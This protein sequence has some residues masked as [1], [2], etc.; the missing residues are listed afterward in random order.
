MFK[1]IITSTVIIA[2]CASCSEKK[3]KQEHVHG[4]GCNHSHAGSA[5]TQKYNQKKETNAHNHDHSIEAAKALG[6]VKVQGIDCKVS[7]S[8]TASFYLVPTKPLAKNTVIR[9][10]IINGNGAESLKS[11]ATFKNGHFSVDVEEAPELD[12]KSKLIIA[13]E[14]N[15][16]EEVVEVTIK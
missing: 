8:C 12:A 5:Y 10:T 7:R 3:E 9:A 15:D 11:K 6:T 14:N 2:L 16:K 1:R 4:P 13:V